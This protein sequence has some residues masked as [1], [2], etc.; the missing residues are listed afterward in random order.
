MT[1]VIGGTDTILSR[2]GGDDAVPT[3]GVPPGTVIAGY[4]VESL[5]GVGGMGVVYRALDTELGRTVALKLIAPERAGDTRLRELF[6]RESLTAAG[7]EHPNVIPIYRAGDDD[8]QLFIAMRFVEGASLQDL[9]AAAPEGIPP[10]RV[11]RIVARVADA[12]DAAHARGLVHRDVK[13]ANVLIAD[14]DGEE[15]VYLSDF[16]LSVHGAGAAGGDGGW[17]GTLAYLAPEQ[18]RGEALDARTDVYALGCVLFHAL[19]GRPPFPTGD[20]QAALQAHLEARPPV[21]SDV[22]PGLPPAFDDVVRRALAKRPEDRFPTAGELGRAALAARYDVALLTAPDDRPAAEGLAAGIRESE[23]LPLVAAAGDPGAVEGIRASGACAVLVG[24]GRPRRLGPRR[25]GRRPR[26]RRPRPRLPPGARPPAGRPRPGRPGPRVPRRAPLGRS[27]LRSRRRAGRGRP[28]ARAARRRRTAR[29]SPPPTGSRPT[30]GSRPSARRTRA[31]TSAASRTSRASSSAC[32]P[33]ASSPSSG[34][35]AAARARSSRPACCRRSAVTPCG[36]RPRLPRDPARRAHPLAALAAQLAHLPGAGSPSPADLAADERALD[37]AVAR[38]LEGRPPDER[39]LIVVD[40]LEEIFT[41]CSDEGE[42]A[43]FL[44]NL[45]YAATIPGGRTVVVTTM[46]ADF[47]HRLAEHPDLR[48]LVATNQ[49]LR[50]PARRPRPA[51]RH[52]GARPP[53]RP[54]ARARPHPPHPHRRRR[55]PRDPARS[56]ST[57]SSSSGAAGA[58]APSPWRPTRASGGV[59][60][61]LARRANEVY[62]AMPPERQAIARRVLLRLTQ[63]G[64]GTEDTRRRAERRELV[65]DPA[66]K[67]EVDAVVDALAEARLVTTGTDEATGE[68]VVEVTHEA[69]IRGWPELRGWIDEDRDRLRAERRLSDAAAEWDRGGRDEGGLYRGARLAAW[70]ERDTTELTP[71]ERD[72]L[73]ES[74]ARAERDRRARRKRV[75]V[76]IGA[77][78]VA[79]AVIAAIAV[80]ALIQRNDANN[81]RDVAT[82]RQL[83]GSSAVARQRDPELATLLGESAYAQSPT[84]E[85]EESLRQGVHDSTIRATLRTPDKLVVAAA[86][87]PGGRLAVGGQSG[88]LQLWDP[89]AD[90]RGASPETVGTWPEGI[91]A[92]PVRDVGGLRDR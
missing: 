71:L 81:Q 72:F 16:G 3:A 49:L 1:D 35:P 19:T 88:A 69:L 37:L 65:T 62:G 38:A 11:A 25:P 7:L 41:L 54:G 15:H 56:S 79:V 4:T 18:I 17:A 86:P 29:D 73:D 57:C 75:K 43:A 58:T 87:A 50:R 6:V 89:A 76:A 90:P 8:G 40:Q 9:I 80:F 22:V 33:P 84:V 30:A 34:R 61:A 82:S 53:L 63:P 83:A 28:R 85:A 67:A 74:S 52:R 64:E 77:L 31:S 92:G 20:E 91:T 42:R 55:P 45:V 70:E 26:D 68:P 47:Y 44:G 14:P 46:R 59:E 39:V 23:L 5:A 2:G 12:L 48:A 60:G 78:S 51:P 10:G 13:P 24:R 32:A 36:E 21:P 66:E 27:A